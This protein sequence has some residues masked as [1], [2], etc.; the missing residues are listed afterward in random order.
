MGGHSQL[1]QYEEHQQTTM[2][3]TTDNN[4]LIIT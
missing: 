3:L 2:Q 4:M 1:L